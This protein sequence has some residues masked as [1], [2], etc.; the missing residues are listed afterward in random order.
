MNM[1]PK[2]ALITGA[3]SG[4]GLELAHEFASHGY[5]LVLVAREQEKLHKVAKTLSR[6]YGQQVEAITLDLTEV[7]SFDQLTQQ[8]KAQKIQ[9][10]VLINNAG[11]GLFGSAIETDY[12]IERN[13]IEL[14]IV[15]L[16][17]L[18]KYF[19]TKM[20]ERGSGSIINV[21]STASFFPGVYM[22]VYYATK[23]YVLSYSLALAEELASS[24]VHVMALCP[25]P[26]K[27]G[28]SSRAHATRTKLFGNPMKARVVAKLAYRGMKSKRRI[29]VT[30]A[31]NKASV[32][33]S[34]LVP[35]GLAA[36]LVRGASQQSK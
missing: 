5:N 29:V 18:T 16:T 2:T 32:F 6:E 30:G 14:N 27:S 19:A 21:A 23:A 36:R 1:T 26:T 31:K 10:D 34:R 24:G 12:S 11:F 28:F 8:L 15:A 35:R 25:G 20:S 9:I 3:S 22:S 33:L 4:I 7:Q 17:R 13:M